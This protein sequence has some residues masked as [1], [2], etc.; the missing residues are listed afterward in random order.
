MGEKFICKTVPD[1]I[2]QLEKLNEIL[3]RLVERMPETE[4]EE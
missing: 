4:K 1:L 3:G 2:R